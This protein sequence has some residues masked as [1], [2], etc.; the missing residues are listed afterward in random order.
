MEVFTF[1][2]E[3]TLKIFPPNTFKFKPKG[4]I[5]HDEIQEYI[6]DNFWFQY[7]NE[8]EEKGYI[9]SILN[10]LAQYFDMLNKRRTFPEKKL[11]FQSPSQYMFYLMERG[12][13]YTYH[14]K[15]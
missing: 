14:L 11:N 4:H 3:N 6:L 9:L 13:E 7:N 1:H 8:R 10:S 12:Q 15:K 5:I 2:I